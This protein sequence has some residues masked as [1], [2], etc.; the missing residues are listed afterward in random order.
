MP[1]TS[2]I[3][4]TGHAVKQA[5][6]P[7]QWA[8]SVRTALPLMMLSAFSGQAFTQ[9]PEPIQRPGL[10]MGC[11]EAGSVKPASLASCSRARPRRLI[12]FLRLT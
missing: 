1:N 7:M 2:S 9:A 10:M 8:A 5:P 6:W 11:I 3:A 12:R 4:S